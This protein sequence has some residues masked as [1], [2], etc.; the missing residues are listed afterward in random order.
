MA[1]LGPKAWY[2]RDDGTHGYSAVPVW[3]NHTAVAG[4]LRRP[5]APAVGAERVVVCI[6]GGA[7]G[8]SQPTWTTTKGARNVSSSATYQECTGQPGVNGDIPVAVVTNS[9]ASSGQTVLGFASVPTSVRVGMLATHA[10]LPLGSSTA[11]VISI[12][13]TTVTL[14]ANIVTN[15]ASGQTIYF[16]NCPMW[17][18]ER[19]TVLTIGLV[20]YDETT[21]SL[22]ICSVAGTTGSSKPSFS[23]TAGTTTADNTVT[24]TSLGLASNFGIWAAPHARL[25][26]A[27]TA[28][29]G[30]AGDHFILADDHAETQAA[31][32]N[33][34]M[35]GTAAAPCSVWC[36]DHTASLPHTSADLRSD[37]YTTTTPACAQ[38]T[39]T[40]AFANTWGGFFN[41]Y[42]VVFNGGTGVTTVGMNFTAIGKFERCSYRKLGTSATSFAIIFPVGD[43]IDCTLQ[44]GATGDNVR[45][46]SGATARW[47]NSSGPAIIGSTI[48]TTL[49]IGNNIGVFEI[50]G[51]DLSAMDTGKT[52]CG[53]I[54]GFTT[55]KLRGVKTGTGVTIAATPT[56][57]SGVVEAIWTD[58]AGTNY[59]QGKWTF[60]GTLLQETTVVRTGGATDGTTP[61]SWKV[62]TT[63]NCSWLNPFEAFSFAI[64]NDTVGSPVTTTIFGT[65]AAVPNN[66]QVWLEESYF[67]NSGDPLAGSVTSG[68]ADNFVQGSTGTSDGV[69]SWGGGTAPFKIAAVCTPQQKGPVRGTVHVGQPSATYYFDPPYANNNLS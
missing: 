14:S 60:Y 46:A 8:A 39:T 7:T 21:A 52:I 1:N 63:A 5:T 15:I 23:A 35:P 31:A 6:I 24:W 13:A 22:Q 47:L 36:V 3:N 25:A 29:W 41:C 27:G 32:I 66:D 17:L 44:F 50:D 59:Q 69:S 56:H 67:K 33:F 58:S 38:I 12:S 11:T 4:E 16:G 57:P 42:G 54:A 61:I 48:P 37:P 43:S 30:A 45:N 26:N 2:V 34:T 19:S 9:L 64:W 62:V 28:T 51:V 10:N 18:N 49:L 68:K 55:F 40:G 53:V 65:G 20:I